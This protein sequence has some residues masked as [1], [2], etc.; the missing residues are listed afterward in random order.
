VAGNREG[1]EDPHQDEERPPLM[2]AFDSFTNIILAIVGLV[3]VFAL[4]ERSRI[5]WLA[6]RKRERQDRA[7]RKD[8]EEQ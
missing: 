5:V 4:F 8:V 7:H 6:R 1:G 2:G 3:I